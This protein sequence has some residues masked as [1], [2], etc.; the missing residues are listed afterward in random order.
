MSHLLINKYLNSLEE[1]KKISGTSRESVIREAFKDLLKNWGKTHDLIFIP[2]YEIE[3]PAKERR[4]VD[5]ALLYKLRVPFGYWEAKDEKDNLDAEI[6]LKFRRGYPGDNIIFEDSREA[7]LYQN[8]QEVIRCAVDNV[9]RLQDLLNSFFSYQRPEIADFRKAVVQFRNDL[10]AVLKSL[11]EM[12]EDSEQKNFQFKEAASDF[13]KHAKDA[14]NPSLTEA[15]VREILIQHI[16][17]EE[18]FSA[19]FPG[20]PFHQDNNVAKELYR[21]ELTFFFGNTKFKI[22]QALAPYYS[23]IRSAAA[24]ISSHHEKQT[25]LKVIYENFYKVYNIKA[26]DR[27]GVVYTPNEIVR[28]I[29]QGADWLCEKHF[30]KNLID[31]GVDILDPATG[32]GTFIC[33]L[34]EHFRGQK[35]KLKNKYLKELHA[36]EVA[37]LP[38]YVANLNIEATFADITDEYIEYPN[39]CFVDTLDNTYALRKRVGDYMGDLFG[40]VTE[41][42]VGRIRRQNSRT[43]SVV[44]GNPPY[45]ANQLNEN[46]NNKNRKY[47]EID[48]RIS[49]T[50][51]AKSKAQKTKVYDMYARFLRWASDRVDENGIVAFVTNRSFIDSRTFDGF[52]KD[53]AEEFNEV[54]IMDLGGDVR[55]NPKLSGTKHNVF[56][57]QT[58]VSISF[59][60]KKSKKSK[61]TKDNTCM[62]FYA[63]RP[64]FDT[65]EDKLSFLANKCLSHIEFDLIKP[66]ERGNWLNQTNNDF[67]DFIPIANKATKSAKILQEKAVFKVVSNGIVTARDEWMTDFSPIS[68][69]KKVAFFCEIFNS[70]R[71]RWKNSDLFATKEKGKRAQVL[72]DFVSRDIKWT[73]ELESH[74]DKDTEISFKNERLRTRTIYRPYVTNSTYYAKAL[75]HR[76]YKQDSIFPISSNWHNIAIGFSGLSSSKSFSSLVVDALPSFDLLE[77]TQFVAYYIY[78]SA[79]NREENITDWALNQF[80][81]HYQHGSKKKQ[82]ITKNSIFHY[83]YAILHNPTYR[84]K[85]AINLKRDFP[86]IPLYRDFWRWSDWGE[87]L[88]DLH[89]G[90]EQKKPYPLIRVETKPANDGI[91][92]VKLRC[93]KEN[94]VIFIDEATSLTGI[95]ATAWEYRLCNRSALEWILNRYKESTPK[96]PTI[97]AKFNTYR[98]ANYK[99][100]VID[101]LMRVTTVSIE[102]MNIVNMMKDDDR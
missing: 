27:L 39:L 42:N 80:R 93:D 76:V 12:I 8:K 38:Y 95:P 16:L 96:D 98:F 83:C 24:Q 79:G 52:R 101:L 84:E 69:S 46:E 23:A 32:T 44:L 21:L 4:Y 85:Y 59:L 81:R 6:E 26:A 18:V 87:A 68:L 35:A 43:I 3:T 37:I 50:Y 25:F 53:V 65:K 97:R 77:K 47:P 2:E 22:L 63:R 60:V 89:L 7:V 74:L 58:G 91:H 28:F 54:W 34:L 73:E 5:G 92:R 66:D 55:V 57:I 62:I 99:E 20:A 36:N 17:T 72:R 29:I 30:G 70:E 61:K 88:M 86:R 1:L 14:I 90:F 67:E 10:P 56:G 11:R 51:F 102:T 19:V 78:D 13:L 64:E 15:D 31:E 82:L 45:N 100:Q 49:E 94:G 71:Q 40:S 75:T 48:K 41:E 9:E 33:E